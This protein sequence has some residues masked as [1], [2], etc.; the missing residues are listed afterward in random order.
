MSL[1]AI[2]QITPSVIPVGGATPADLVLVALQRGASIEQLGQL[3][4][5][6]FRW[7]AREAEKSAVLAMTEFKADPPVIF[8]NKQVEF[9]GTSYKH[10]TIGDVTGAVTAGL[11]KHGFSHRWSVDQPG[12]GQIIVSCVLT[13]K[14]GHSFSTSLTASADTSGKKNPIQAMASAVTYLQRYTLLLATGLA[15]HDQEDDDGKDA[16]AAS[17][18]HVEGVLQDLMSD[19]QHAADDAAVIAVWTIGKK[20]LAGLGDTTA[21]TEFRAA[22]AA[23]RQQLGAKQ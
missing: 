3:M 12:D 7:E 5:L 17:P 11:S 16:G 1:T 13:H 22:V 8:K 2:E 18:R 6:Q 20:I 15:T 19:V 23:R 14:L 10:A 9:S 21:S 4:E